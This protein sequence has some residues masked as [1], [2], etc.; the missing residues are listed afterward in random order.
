LTHAAE[1]KPVG[2]IGIGAVGVALTACCID[3]DIEVFG[4]RRG[5]V[6]AFSAAGGTLCESNVALAA[7]VAQ[8]IIVV[9]SDA[10]LFNVMAEIEPVLRPDHIVLC[11]GTHAVSIKQRAALIAER[12]TAMFLDGEISGTPE[13]VR[14]GRASV[15]LAG[16][17]SA[18][19]S[20]RETLDRVVPTVAFVGTFGNAVRMKLLT[21]YLVGVHT[22]AAAEALLLGKR[23]GLDPA[24]AVSA[25]APSAGGSTMLAVRGRMMAEGR[26]P[27]GS[28][29]SFVRYF[30]LMR[31]TLDES[32]QLPGDLFNFTESLYRRAIAEGHGH[33][34]IAAMYDYLGESD[35]NASYQKAILP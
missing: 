2:I 9:Q 15:F 26:F 12:A 18:V 10:A 34:D 20:I 33:R 1:A 28:M 29:T 13:M 6:E 5:R 17:M 4:P 27:D 3:A 19:A 16:D 11:L 31:Q 35:V 25:I 21:N 32:G 30:D 23:L 24:Q 14:N 8:L 22:L 7:K